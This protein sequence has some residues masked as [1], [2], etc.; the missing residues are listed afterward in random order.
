MCSI[1]PKCS[2]SFKKDYNAKIQSSN[3]DYNVNNKT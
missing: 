3:K 1:F 2:T